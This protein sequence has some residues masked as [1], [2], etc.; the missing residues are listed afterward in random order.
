DHDRALLI[1]GEGNRLRLIFRANLEWLCRGTCRELSVERLSFWQVT[2][3]R[4]FAENRLEEAAL[5]TLHAAQLAVVA[6]HCDINGRHCGN[7]LHD[8]RHR[9]SAGHGL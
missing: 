3:R 9:N 6:F 2:R 7:G 4:V 1:T 5:R 8:L